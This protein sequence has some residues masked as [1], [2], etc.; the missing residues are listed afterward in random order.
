MRA[1]EPERRSGWRTEQTRHCEAD[2][3]LRLRGNDDGQMGTE[4]ASRGSV[5]GDGHLGGRPERE[6]RVSGFSMS[7]AWDIAE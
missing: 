3:S 7:L 5:K 1:S 6:A 2:Q 4:L